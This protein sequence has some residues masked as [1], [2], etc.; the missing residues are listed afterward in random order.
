M[1]HSWRQ[2][3]GHSPL[4]RLPMLDGSET[5]IQAGETI[6]ILGLHIDRQLV[7]NQHVS[8]ATQKAKNT[9]VGLHILANTIWGVSQME[10]CMMYRACIVPIMMYMSPVW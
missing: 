5:V 8:K 2:D 7:F 10:L 3:R 9:V 4:I 1:H 6:R